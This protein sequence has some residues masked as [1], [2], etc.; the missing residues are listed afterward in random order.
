MTNNNII[1]ASAAPPSLSP[2]LLSV[3]S[4]LPPN[5]QKVFIRVFK[6]LW[7]V[8][9]PYRR[10]AG[11]S[12]LLLSFWAVD[13]I[14][15]RYSLCN[16]E[17][18]LLSYIYQQTGNNKYF[19]HSDLIYNSV[20]FPGFTRN[21][22][23]VRLCELNNK[24]FVVRSTSD[25]AALHLRRSHARQPVFIKLSLKG[26]QVIEAMEKDLYKLLLNTSLDELTGANLKK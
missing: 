3:Y 6:Y 21:S 23:Q 11:P 10:V 17:L 20:M 4:S 9:L 2:G 8:V 18:S 24:G 16:S 15:E 5:I 12:G 22:K 25:P 1:E 14:R 26:V 7:G 19:I 13:L